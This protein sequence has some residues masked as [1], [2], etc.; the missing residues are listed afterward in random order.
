MI[1]LRLSD[2]SEGLA[3]R[4]IYTAL[5]SI[6]S[7]SLINCKKLKSLPPLDPTNILILESIDQAVSPNALIKDALKSESCNIIVIV[8]A[9][10]KATSK[11]LF[12][13]PLLEH[14]VYTQAPLVRQWKG[15]RVIKTI[16]EIGK[17]LLSYRPSRKKEPC[18][19]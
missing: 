17:L 11:A 12:G 9:N 8:D 18:H 13:K 3:K 19:G 10:P 16:E 7:F 4:A 2:A 1:I 6:D 15:L 14:V 5:E